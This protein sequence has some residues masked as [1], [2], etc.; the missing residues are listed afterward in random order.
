M[1]YELWFNKG[2]KGESL[3]DY[4]SYAALSKDFPQV[5]KGFEVKAK[6]KG[7]DISGGTYTAQPFRYAYEIW[8]TSKNKKHDDALGSYDT[9]AEAK[10]DLPRLKKEHSEFAQRNGFSISGGK[11][12][13][14]P[15]HLPEGPEERI[16]SPTEDRCGACEN[17]RKRAAVDKLVKASGGLEGADLDITAMWESSEKNYL[18]SKHHLTCERCGKSIDEVERDD[19]FGFCAECAPQTELLD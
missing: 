12:T 1:R 19:N 10:K 18:C 15:F 6:R 17:C 5:K 13:I 4:S 2:G 8:W 7:V 11:Y 14:E 16:L 3:G 9:P